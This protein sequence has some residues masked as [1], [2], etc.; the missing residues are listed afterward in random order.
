MGANLDGKIRRQKADLISVMEELDKKAERQELHIEEWR[1][2]YKLERDLE[3]I[4]SFQEKIWQQWC[5][6]KWVLQGDANTRFFHGV[7]NG[8]RCALFFHCKHKRGIY[9][10]LLNYASI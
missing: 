6:A 8:R 2:K 5:S 10:N 1:Y 9:L 7:A 3:E 4:F